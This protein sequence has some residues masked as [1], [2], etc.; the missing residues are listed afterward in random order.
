[1][2]TKP[3]WMNPALTRLTCFACATEHDAAV[4]QNVCTRCGLPLRVDYDHALAP[5]SPA[6]LRGRAPSLWRYHEVLPI[7]PAHATSLVEGFTPLLPITI[8]ED[9]ALDATSRLAARTGLDICP[10]GG[11]AYAA[12]EALLPADRSPPPIASSCSTPAPG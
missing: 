7:L 12:L 11:A 1:M 4:P 10:E 8:A 9:D 6:A 3:E 2:P 5:L